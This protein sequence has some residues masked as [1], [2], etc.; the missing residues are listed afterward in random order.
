MSSNVVITNEGLHIPI[1]I[2]NIPFDPIFGWNELQNP[3]LD[4]RL[5]DLRL[6]GKHPLGYYMLHLASIARDAEIEQPDF[7]DQLA[8]GLEYDLPFLSD[9]MMRAAKDLFWEAR[10]RL[11]G[12]EEDIEETEQGDDEEADSLNSQDK[13]EDKATKNKKWYLDRDDNVRSLFYRDEFLQGPLTELSMGLGGQKPDPRRVKRAKNIERVRVERLSGQLWKMFFR[14]KAA[15]D[16]AKKRLDLWKESQGPRPTALPHQSSAPSRI[17][18]LPLSQGEESDAGDQGRFSCD[19]W[20]DI[21][22]G[23]N[24]YHEFF[25]FS[26]APSVG[27][28]VRLKK[29][30]NATRRLRGKAKPAEKT[31]AV[32]KVFADSPDGRTASRPNLVRVLNY[33]PTGNFSK[34]EAFSQDLKSEGR[35]ALDRLR[36]FMAGLSETFRTLV[37]FS[38]KPPPAF[39]REGED[40]YRAAFLIRYLFSE[41]DGVHFGRAD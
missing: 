33:A 11:G 20:S 31:I 28:L 17:P 18:V 41:E 4:E 26:P 23:I 1:P 21:A 6:H 12:E 19:S 35:K 2:F 38:Q 40:N 25:I 15:Y 37:I 30:F 14:T 3:F 10:K 22:L 32:L 24:E 36:S 5:G 7:L 27:A 9:L 39:P 34:E 29:G 8:K 13:F 16:D